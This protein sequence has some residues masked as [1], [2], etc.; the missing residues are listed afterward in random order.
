MKF[1]CMC[2]A[3]LAAWWAGAASSSAAE[4]YLE[5][6]RGLRGRG[7]FDYALFYLDQIQNDASLPEDVRAVL[8]YERAVTLMNSAQSLTNPEVQNRQLDEALAYLEQFTQAHPDHP[9]AGQAETERGNILLNKGR[10]QIWQSKSPANKA[11]RQPLQEEARRFIG[12]ARDIFQAAH[13][14]HK[15]NYEKFPSFIDE[16]A[17]PA[18]YE[19]RA[20]AEIRFIRAQLDLAL[21]TYE[22][23]Q[24]HDEGSTPYKQ[25]LTQA[26]KEFTAIHEKYRS[27]VG[28]LYARVWEGKCWE[29]QGELN[30]AIGIYNELL[31]H[32][33]QSETMQRLQDQVR[34]FRLICL[35]HDDRKDYQLVIQEADEWMK[36]RKSR[37]RTPVGLGIQWEL[38]RAQEALGLDRTLADEERNRYLR[39]ALATAREINRYPGQYKDVS[40]FMIRRLQVAMRGEEGDPQDFDTAYAL[41][42]NLVK[43]IKDM[44]GKVQAA[45]SADEKKKAQQD[46]ELHLNETARML[47]LALAL[48][49]KD[50][51]ITDLNQTRYL[52]CYV[53]Y[54]TRKSYES[55]ILGEFVARHY[56][57]ED[58]QTA[59]DAAYLA[60]AAWVQA[61]N[62]APRENRELEMNMLARVA[63]LIA[64]KW[65]DS[66][67]AQDARMTLG[68][69]YTQQDRPVEAAAAYSRIPDSSPQFGQAQLAAGQAYWTA[70]LKA[71]SKPEAERTVTAE[72]LAAW[73]TAAESHL[74]AGIEKLQVGTPA[75]AAPPDELIAGKVSLAQILINTGKDADAIALLTTEPHSV[76]NAL[77]VDQPQDRPAQ[78]IKSAAFAG[79]CYQL[80][81][82]GYVGTRQIDEA[83]EAM[84]KLDEI[85]GEDSMAVYT[86]L[87]RELENELK[88]SPP[89]RQAQVRSA[90]EAFLGELFKRPNQTYSSLIWIAETYYGLAVGMGEGNPEATPYFEKAAET[91]QS[92]FNVENRPEEAKLTGVKLRLVNCRRQQKK[93][94]E[95]FK[96]VSEI[97]KAKPTALDAQVEAAYVLQDWGA[98]GQAGSESKLMDAIKGVPEAGAWGWGQ[99]IVRLQR[100]IDPARPDPDLENRL[101]EARYN[102]VLAQHKYAMTQSSTQKESGLATAKRGIESLVLVG[103]RIPDEWWDKFAVL[104]LKVQSDM[105]V[106]QPQPLKRATSVQVVAASAEKPQPAASEAPAAPAAASAPAAKQPPAGPNVAVLL[107]AAVVIGGGAFAFVFLMGKKHRKVPRVLADAAPL[108]GAIPVKRRPAEKAVVGEGAPPAGV[109]PKVVKKKVVKGVPGAPPPA[110]AEG[111]RRVIKKKKRPAPPA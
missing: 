80:L 93:F 15:A 6:V 108:P 1:R 69:I 58:S 110:L 73:Q 30:K 32:P 64:E 43:S 34:Q 44:E 60:M 66:D 13:D 5:F 84:R 51:A 38:A 96:L 16:S 26:A 35:N 21:C 27:M 82:R 103:T 53:Y 76:M 8:S 94:D 88:R 100:A 12:Q 37:L 25:T 74:R 72:D 71:Y 28:G 40:M 105:G 79:L 67:R 90:F 55:A 61:F 59:L 91:Y 78:G 63:E 101:M 56:V 29:E 54:L 14:K 9:L 46:L 99:L 70:Y 49:D 52:L 68:R 109:R 10:V 107:I 4:P 48:A 86:Q 45:P 111:E 22:M 3:A 95:A 47:G 50:V 97:V 11:N 23:A 17:D 62:D 33:G 2:C 102:S 7:Y 20:Q 77:A 36:K 42:R 104:Y 81:L 98:S 85:G 19:Q 106:A 89:E 18:L 24:T 41:A 75:E 92:I 65:P 57:A 83:L 39:Q 87:G 31:Q